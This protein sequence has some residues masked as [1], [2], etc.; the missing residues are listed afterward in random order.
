MCSNT[1]TYRV[2]LGKGTPLGGVPVIVALNG[3]ERENGQSIVW[4]LGRHGCGQERENTRP[5]G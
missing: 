4:L 3:M 1:G 2:E 5:T